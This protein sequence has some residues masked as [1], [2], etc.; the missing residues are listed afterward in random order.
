MLKTTHPSQAAW[1]AY[2]PVA[3]PISLL[4]S[5]F[6]AFVF[7][8]QAATCA[9]GHAQTDAKLRQIFSKYPANSQA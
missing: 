8:A 3:S 9:S 6:F 5:F 7:E 2:F 4:C 1:S